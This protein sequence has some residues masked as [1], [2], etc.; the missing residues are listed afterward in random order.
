M[1]L[2]G[3]RVDSSRT[4]TEAATR[5]GP[6][7]VDPSIGVLEGEAA[8]QRV[9]AEREQR[10]AP[11]YAVWDRSVAREERAPADTT[12]YDRPVIKEPTWIWTVPLYF[13]V[14][15][16]AGAATVLGAVAQGFE[17]RSL[18]RLV[19]Q[20]R[21]MGAV[22]S[23]VGSG[24]LISDLGRPERFLNMLRVFRPTSPMNVGSWLLAGLGTL[25]GASAM[26]SRSTGLLG[27]AGNAA[28]CGAALL[29][30]P[31][32]GYTAVLVSQTAVPAWQE[33]RRS[34]PLLFIGSAMGAA[35][36]LL[37]LMPLTPRAEDVVRRFGMVG[38][39]AS[40]AGMLAVE[41]EVAR[42][43]RVA[44]PLR[45][46]P[47]AALWNAARAAELVGLLLSGRPG[48]SRPRRIAAALLGTA[49]AL[50]L[51][52]AVLFLG[53]ASARDPRATFRQQRAGRGAAEVAGAAGIA[54]PGGERGDAPGPRSR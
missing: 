17:H 54:G 31:L 27:R 14:G 18:E 10:G 42:V 6:R 2:V 12:Y 53:K 39:I 36:S 43:D 25:A 41:R 21:W 20:C 8:H 3:D 26:L 7:H 52:F 49:A 34:L 32:A 38:Q 44:A 15:G 28:A 50:G 1:R 19:T 46:G 4:P 5:G 37:E 11:P 33:A 48:R 13:Y 47:A 24:L 29:G 23:A 16:A 35:A 9:P 40:L 22:G 45:R 51:R 30:M